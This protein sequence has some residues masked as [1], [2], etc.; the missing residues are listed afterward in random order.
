MRSARQCSACCP[1]QAGGDGQ[2]VGLGSMGLRAEPDECAQDG[3]KGQ[4]LL[5]GGKGERGVSAESMNAR[6][7]ERPLGQPKL[8]APCSTP[9]L[10]PALPLGPRRT[11]RRRSGTWPPSATSWCT[12]AASTTSR[13][14]HFSRRCLAS[15]RAVSIW[16]CQA[17]CFGVWRTFSAAARRASLG[18]GSKP[19]RTAV[20]VLHAPRAPL[21]PL[22]CPCA[23]LLPPPSWASLA[24]PRRTV[25]ALSRAI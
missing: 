1:R 14:A 20:G 23:P 25:A 2:R 24:C 7:V 21:C 18:W 3:F 17:V 12:S 4:L 19:R 15:G 10:P 13:W 6:A 9:G 16:P 11:C 8:R 5:G 22:A